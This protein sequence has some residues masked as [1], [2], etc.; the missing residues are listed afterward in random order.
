[1]AVGSAAALTIPE[2]RRENEL[3]G[4]ARDSLVQQ[5]QSTAH[6]TV[7]KVQ[8]VVEEVGETVEKETQ[9]DGSSTNR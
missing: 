9:S 1:M 6:S 7:H 8:Q 2:S 5:A 4:E 3:M